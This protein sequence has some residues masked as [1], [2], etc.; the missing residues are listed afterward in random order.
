MDSVVGT[1]S[2][3]RRVHAKGLAR[4]RAMSQEQ[5]RETVDAAS[6]RV[7][8]HN[9]VATPGFTMPN[10]RMFRWQG[11]GVFFFQP[12]GGIRGGAPRGVRELENVLS[13]QLPNGF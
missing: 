13:L 1:V 11:F 4:Y 6:Q 8:E 5:R 2:F 3:R 7:L 10:R 9:W 12:I